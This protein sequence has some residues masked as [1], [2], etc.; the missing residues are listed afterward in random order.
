MVIGLPEDTHLI[1]ESLTNTAD[2]FRILIRNLKF[3]KNAATCDIALQVKISESDRKF[4]H[5]QQSNYDEKIMM[6]GFDNNPLWMNAVLSSSSLDEK[7]QCPLKFHNVEFN[8]IYQDKILI[9]HRSEGVGSHVEFKACCFQE[10]KN[11]NISSDS[12]SRECFFVRFEL[13]SRLN[14]FE[15]VLLAHC[16]QKEAKLKEFVNISR[17]KSKAFKILIPQK[18]SKESDPNPFNSWREI[19]K[20]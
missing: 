17:Q 10:M 5:F 3:E 7:L 16:S 15:E 1:A 9:P 12:F 18:E 6:L 19:S 4:F 11:L 8:I 20:R 13:Q 2:K 14:N